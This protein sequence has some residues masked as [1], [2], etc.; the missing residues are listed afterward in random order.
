MKWFWKSVISKAPKW[1][2]DQ[3]DDEVL[4]LIWKEI[5][6]LKVKKSANIVK[7]EVTSA[8]NRQQIEDM[9]SDTDLV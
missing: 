4:E 2:W 8:I 3:I 1:V 5:L 9:R 6:K 7:M